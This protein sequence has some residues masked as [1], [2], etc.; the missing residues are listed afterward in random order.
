MKKLRNAIVK[1]I[2]EAEKAIAANDAAREDAYVADISNAELEL[3]LMCLDA[4]R[5]AIWSTIDKLH[6]ALA[7]LA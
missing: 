4:E 5:S 3:K 1:A 2:A 7:Q 6:D